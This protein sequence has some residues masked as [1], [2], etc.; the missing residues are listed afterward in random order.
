M[1]AG[2]PPSNITL[3]PIADDR[4]QLRLLEAM[5]FASAGPLSVEDM[6][7]HLPGEADID[8][9][10]TELKSFYASRGVN[11]VKVAGKWA[12]RTAPDLGFLLRHER[13]EEKRL[14]KAALETLAIIAYHQ[15]VTRAEIEEIRG[16]SASK[17]TLDTLMELEW[18][19]LRGR[20]QTPG[21]PVT[22]GVT[23]AFLDQFGLETIGDLPGLSE[24]KA[25]GF[26][27]S[28]LPD[29]IAVPEPG[30]QT[31]GLDADLFDPGET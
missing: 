12:F 15:P 20:R 22:Y 29:G 5:L 27:S 24:L 31:G 26:L 3:L 18:I 2:Q 1:S 6:R 16:V 9:L 8:A 13:H 4:Q 7:V 14:S 10:L 28:R 17:G 11:L 30:E 23:D 19:R 21:R 25:S